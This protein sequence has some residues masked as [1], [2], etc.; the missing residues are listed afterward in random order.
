MSPQVWKLARGGFV[1]Q[2]SLATF[3]TSTNYLL[4]WGQSV[5]AG[6]GPLGV[7]V[8]ASCL[9]TC[10]FQVLSL[11][12]ASYPRPDSSLSWRIQS[13][14]ALESKLISYISI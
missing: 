1:E 9:G 8:R 5:V 3:L 14:E 4:A 7:L 13:K 10:V 6:N 12:P 11:H 2:A